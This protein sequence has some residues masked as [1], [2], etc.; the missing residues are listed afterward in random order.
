MTQVL[1]QQIITRDDL[2]N[3]PDVYYLFGDNEQRF[4]LK[5]QAAAMRGE[6]NAIGI[7]TKRAPR[8]S[9]DAFWSDDNY[10]EN[11]KMLEE[12]FA[13]VLDMLSR[14]HTIVIPS[15]GIGTG[16]SNLSKYAPQTSVY[17]CKRLNQLFKHKA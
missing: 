17:V 1:V 6:H 9:P 13:I 8:R 11:V 10:A 15:D 16:L 12:D 3:N 5:G 14:G 7:R 2:R 4:G